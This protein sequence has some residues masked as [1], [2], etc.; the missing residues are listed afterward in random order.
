MPAHRASAYFINYTCYCVLSPFA[1]VMYW[2][3]CRSSIR[4][5]MST[6]HIQWD[7]VCAEVTR[8]IM[9][10]GN[11][12][13]ASAWCA[14]G[15]NASQFLTSWCAICAGKAH[16]AAPFRCRHGAR[17]PPA[18]GSTGIYYRRGSYKR[19]AT[20]RARTRTCACTAGM[21]GSEVRPGRRRIPP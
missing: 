20:H 8:C 10:T 17:L 16:A 6:R 9:P 2:F 11:V 19:C 13:C 1:S 4:R 3:A 15:A 7:S 12:R 18:G 5:L 21:R 14:R